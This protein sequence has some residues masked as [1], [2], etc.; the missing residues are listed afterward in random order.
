[1][2]SVAW[3][4]VVRAFHVCSYVRLG[5]VF[6]IGRVHSRRAHSFSSP[7]T[8]TPQPDLTHVSSC[9]QYQCAEGEAHTYVWCNGVAIMGDFV[10]TLLS[11][12]CL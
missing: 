6:P 4:A 9:R 1:M 10:R 12:I 5:L 7:S 11:R 8:I 2:Y 3:A